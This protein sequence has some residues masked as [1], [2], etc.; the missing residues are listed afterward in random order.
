MSKP[1]NITTYEELEERKKELD[2]EVE[3]SQR[4]L[5][6]SLGTSRV[7]LK[8]FLIK[9]V[10]LPIGGAIAGVW[11]IGKFKKKPRHTHSYHKETIIKSADDSQDKA[12]NHYPVPPPR[13]KKENNKKFKPQRPQPAAAMATTNEEGKAE[14]RSQPKKD[15]LMAPKNKKHLIN[16]ATLASVA[17][18]AVP[19]VKMIVKAVRDHKDQQSTN[20]GVTAG[21]RPDTG[22]TPSTGVGAAIGAPQTAVGHS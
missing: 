3:A 10:A 12:T 22:A 6:H 8:D 1:Q 21:A 11:L 5:A 20:D 4:E 17:K 13:T 14:L 9:K 7:N 2:L 16:M 18:I 15:E 19:A